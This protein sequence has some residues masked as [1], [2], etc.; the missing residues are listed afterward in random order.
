M[1][2]ENAKPR[3]KTSIQNKRI[4]VDAAG[5]RVIPFRGTD[6]DSDVV[7][8]L[9]FSDAYKLRYVYEGTSTCLL[10]TSDAADE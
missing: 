6:Y 4:V 5:D 7:E 3:L 10:Y 2:V 8:T 1:E 9:S